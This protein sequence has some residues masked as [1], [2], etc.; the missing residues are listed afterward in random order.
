MSRVVSDSFMTGLFSAFKIL[1]ETFD[2]SFIHAFPFAL[3]H[4][5]VDATLA[6]VIAR[7]WR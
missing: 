3:V 1:D 5:L 6:T 4:K 2:N 7:P